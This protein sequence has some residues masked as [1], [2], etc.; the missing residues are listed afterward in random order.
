[1]S[2][3]TETIGEDVALLEGMRT[4]RAIRRFKSD[5]V[6]PELI[7]KVAEAG[8]F[9]PSGGNRQP[10]VFVAVTDAGRRRE[11]AAY[12]K[13]AFDAYI[14]P[15][16]KAAADPGFPSSR[17]KAMEGA[18]HLAENLADVPVHF[19]VAGWT[20]RGQ[21]QPQSI[22]PAVQNIL[23]ACRAV[24]LGSCLTTLHRAFGK[25]IDELLGLDENQLSYAL[26][27]IGWPRG[28]YTKPLRRSVDECLFFDRYRRP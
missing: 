10:W 4:A 26:L 25:E 11:I 28:A 24:G 13:K 18:I 23:L 16:R 5:P 8:T 27:P 6:P 1:M 9:A 22:F 15:A 17:R 21:E 20:R 12:Y 14:E 3:D 19:F 7:R 2:L